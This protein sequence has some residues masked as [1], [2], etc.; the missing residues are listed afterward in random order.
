MIPVN[1]PLVP[2]EAKQYISA[3]L[4]SG[5]ISSAGPY[6]T[7]FE[8]DFARYCAC[9]H[10]IAVCNGTVALHLALAALNIGPGDEVI[11]PA[12]TIISCLNAIV[13]TGATPVIVDVEPDTFT[14]D[15]AC[16]RQA[17][18]PRTKAIMPV[19]L[20][21]HPADMD[22]LNAIARDHGLAVVEDAAEAHGAAYKGA[23]CGGLGTLAAF[24]FYPNKLITTG[25]GGM[26]LTNDAALAARCR[27]LRDL[28]HLP[29]QRF[30]HAELG[31]NYRMASLQAALGCAQLLHI[32]A[33]FARKQR[34]AR[35][36]DIGL[37]DVPGLHTPVTR[38][39]ALNS[40]WMYAV[41]L[42]PEA[43][44]G[45]DACCARLKEHGVDTRDFFWSLS[46]QPLLRAIQA[47]VMACPVSERLARE[48]FYLPSGLALT[49]A[50]IA[51][52]IAAV[53]AVLGAAAA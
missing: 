2:P 21:G 50:E 9:M 24:S 14:I 27:S 20:Y 10:G 5:W 13:Y 31:F 18:S 26:V 23:R 52:V 42:A 46:E 34:M 6:V 30:H 3:C 8:T 51:T 32:D 38:S 49:D 45:R 15:P 33:Y 29:G 40:Y 4:D 17:L 1:A 16:V 22:A 35:L 39:W 7:Q 47:R 25:E 41:R 44:L 11:V 28:C 19:H 36:Y 48:G 37:H 43:R 53:R 12:M